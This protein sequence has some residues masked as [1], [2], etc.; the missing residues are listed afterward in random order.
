MMINSKSRQMISRTTEIRTKREDE[1]ELSQVM[2]L[3]FESCKTSKKSSRSTAIV[4]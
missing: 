4:D 1:E 3:M 2:N